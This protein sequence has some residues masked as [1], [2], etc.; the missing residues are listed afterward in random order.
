MLNLV[1]EEQQ[2]DTM[3]HIVLEE[4]SRNNTAQNEVPS[5]PHRTFI[6]IVPDYDARFVESTDEHINVPETIRANWI[7]KET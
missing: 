7:L 5:P 6:T 2:A 4:V 1:Q 3:K